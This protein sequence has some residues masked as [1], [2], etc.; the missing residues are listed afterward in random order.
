MHQSVKFHDAVKLA[1]GQRELSLATRKPTPELIARAKEILA[2]PENAPQGHVRERVYA[3]RTLNLANAPE[4]TEIVLQTFRIGELGVAAIPFEV[5]AETGLEIKAQS[6][7]KP[8]F[9]VSLANGSNGYLPTPPQHQLGGYETW[10][11]TNRVE[12]EASV[13]I[14]R[15][16]L[17]Q[18]GKLK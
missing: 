16:L 13:K 14:V 4:R 3:Q 17:E 10:L 2:R 9:T 12:I 6:P 7:F 1:A 5:F 15:S 8:T 18:F 11:G